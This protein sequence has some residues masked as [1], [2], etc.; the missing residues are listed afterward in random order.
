MSKSRWTL[1]DLGYRA[2][3]GIPAIHYIS[4]I[5][6]RETDLWHIGTL[7]VA[8]GR[9]PSTIRKWEMAGF[10]PPTPFRTPN[11]A[12]LYTTE[13][14]D[15]F[16]QCCNLYKVAQGRKMSNYFKRR[17]REEFKRINDKFLKAPEEPEEFD[18]ESEE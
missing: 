12:R 11:G 7:A 3:W 18:D 14:V 6:G 1:P 2:E 8:I 4:P 5:T 15:V 10:I 17:L 16:V 9:Q 13:H